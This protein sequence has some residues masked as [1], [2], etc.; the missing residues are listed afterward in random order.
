MKGVKIMK[1]YKTVI[2]FEDGREFED[3]WVNKDDAYSYISRADKFKGCLRAFMHEMIPD[4][5]NLKYEEGECMYE[6][7]SDG[8]YYYKV[9]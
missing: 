1:F 9:A 7:A 6:Y 2:I 5:S 4:E 3:L 8:F